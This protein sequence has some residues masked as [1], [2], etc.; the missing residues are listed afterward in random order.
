M[1]KCIH[2]DIK[3]VKLID[4]FLKYR[5]LSVE[6]KILNSSLVYFDFKFSKCSCT[7]PQNRVLWGGVGRRDRRWRPGRR[8]AAA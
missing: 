1:R 8:S 4:K 2:Y 7:L 6:I 3:Y 5:T